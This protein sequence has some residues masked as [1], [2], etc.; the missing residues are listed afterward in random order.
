MIPRIVRLALGT[1]SFLG[2]DN[3]DGAEVFDY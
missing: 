3:C 2:F 1:Q